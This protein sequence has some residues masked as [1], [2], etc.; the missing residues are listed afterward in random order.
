MLMRNRKATKIAIKRL[1]KANDHLKS[2]RQE[3]FYEEISQALWGYLSD[4][5]GIPLADLSMD[6]ISEALVNKNVNEE[7][8]TQFTE[9][10]ND[11]EF[12]R[13]APG[14]KS[15]TMERTYNK[16][17]EIITKIERELR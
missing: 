3:Q 8:L 9:T 14:D 5:F 4:K 13:F 11:T 17:L 16:A 2:G 6:S 7:I 1:K 15:L 10:L 12:A